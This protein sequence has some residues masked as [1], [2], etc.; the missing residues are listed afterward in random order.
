[1]TN[2]TE[3]KNEAIIEG[4][5]KSYKWAGEKIGLLLEDFKQLLNAKD[6]ALEAAKTKL[7][8]SELHNARLSGAG[9]EW[10]EMLTKHD[11]EIAQAEKEGRSFTTTYIV[12][13]ILARK[14]FVEALSSSP[15]DVMEKLGKVV[16]ALETFCK[17]SKYF[18]LP[19]SLYGGAHMHRIF[20]QNRERALE[21]ALAILQ[22]MGVSK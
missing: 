15:S 4:L 18:P 16:E 13:A 19:Y 6:A 21:E 12:G 9:K 22:E 5:Y 8:T 1:M 10:D 17:R 7:T 11:A 20:H 3:Q 2:P 14:R